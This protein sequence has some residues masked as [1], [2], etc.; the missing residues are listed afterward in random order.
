MQQ[1]ETREE[2]DFEALPERLEATESAELSCRAKKR[3]GAQPIKEK[4]LPRSPQGV[5][6]RG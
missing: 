3:C 4:Y 1:D 5:I 2:K 6:N